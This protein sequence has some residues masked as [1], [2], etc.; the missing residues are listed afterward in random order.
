MLI[1]PKN[2]HGRNP[3]SYKVSIYTII[4]AFLNL[5]A[6]PAYAQEIQYK[7][8]EF[9]KTISEVF[10]PGLQSKPE[11]EFQQKSEEKSGYL[12]DSVDEATSLL[13]SYQEDVNSANA[14][15]DKRITNELSDIIERLNI[16]KDGLI[17]EFVSD[18]KNLEGLHGDD[19]LIDRHNATVKKF[20]EQF[21]N[22]I[23]LLSELEST[24]INDAK[25]KEVLRE[26]VDFSESI[27]STSKHKAF[28]PAKM[29]YKAQNDEKI[30]KPLLITVGSE[31][32][33]KHALLK[34]KTNLPAFEPTEEMKVLAQQLDNDPVKIYNWVYNNIAF[35]P[36]YGAIQGNDITFISKSGNTVDTNIFSCRFVKRCWYRYQV[37]HRYCKFN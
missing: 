24:S 15:K 1:F 13:L 31:A 27:K 11:L 23:N 10:A 22:Y 8:D 7:R 30:E 35:K 33:S 2:R 18:R 34:T 28:D 4:V 6:M 37:F 25:Y 12:T 20:Q 16:E 29:G 14:F 36:S 19:V 32:V 17:N 26:A 3:V 5:I 21:A 9:E